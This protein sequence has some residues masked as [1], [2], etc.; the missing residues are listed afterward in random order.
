VPKDPK[1]EED[2]FGGRLEGDARGRV[3]AD[4]SPLTM[5]DGRSTACELWHIPADFLGWN[6]AQE[7]VGV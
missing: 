3:N 4:D 6:S 7:W 5:D 2:E 1:V